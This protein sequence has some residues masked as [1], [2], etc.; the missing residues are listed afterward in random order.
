ML[1]VVRTNY[2]YTLSSRYFTVTTV[3]LKTQGKLSTPEY[4][5]SKYVVRLCSFVVYA[6]RTHPDVTLFALHVPLETRPRAGFLKG[7]SGKGDENEIQYQ[8]FEIFVHLTAK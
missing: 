4:V 8:H 1:L 6:S 3:S 2:L 5:L 7:K